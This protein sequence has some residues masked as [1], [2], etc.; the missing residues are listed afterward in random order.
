VCGDTLYAN[1]HETASPQLFIP[2][3]RQTQVRR[4][5]YMIRT[6]VAPETIVPH[7]EKSCTPPIRAAAGGRAHAGADR[8]GSRR[9][10]AAR[11]A[12][13]GVGSSRVLLHRLGSTA[14][15]RTRL[16]SGTKE[17][18]IRMALGAIRGRFWPWCFAKP[19][20]CRRQRPRSRG[21]V[22]AR[23]TIREGDAV[24]HRSV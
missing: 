5:T 24:R 4:L 2:Y 14:S 7:C 21:R 8:R 16:R 23:Y 18:G 13:V 1:L 12:H 20:R 15:W 11:L 19:R 3:A 22:I 9:R 6:Q 10:T 17:I